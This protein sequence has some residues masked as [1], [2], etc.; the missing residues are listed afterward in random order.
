MLSDT[1]WPLQA[2]GPSE[3]PSEG[4]E[5]AQNAEA[6]PSEDGAAE[7]SAVPIGPPEQPKPMEKKERG[8]MR[9]RSGSYGEILVFCAHCCCWLSCDTSLQHC[10]IIAAHFLVQE[11]KQLMQLK[12]LP[13]RE[14]RRWLFPIWEMS[15]TMETWIDQSQQGAPVGSDMITCCWITGHLLKLQPLWRMHEW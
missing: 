12:S 1:L 2:A 6:P 5:H 13:Q 10:V 8:N 4:F 11:S 9:K 7:Q 3:R 14:Y 15:T